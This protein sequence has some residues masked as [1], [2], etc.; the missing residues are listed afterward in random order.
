MRLILTTIILTMFAQPIWA[1][2]APV[3]FECEMKR[4]CDLNFS[5]MDKQKECREPIKPT[6]QELIYLGKEPFWFGDKKFNFDGSFLYRTSAYRFAGTREEKVILGVVSEFGDFIYRI[7][8]FKIGD[9][10][11][12]TWTSHQNTHAKYWSCKE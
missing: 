7:T 3:T 8:L 11:I 9:E 12:E 6:K 5:N 2:D 10:V 1:D 4:Y